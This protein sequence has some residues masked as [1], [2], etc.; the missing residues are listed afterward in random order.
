[1]MKNTISQKL[2]TVNCFELN[3]LELF[4]LPTQCTVL[5]KMNKSILV[6]DNFQLHYHFK[7]VK[8]F[9]MLNFQR[10]MKVFKNS[11]KKH[12]ITFNLDVYSLGNQ[13]FCHCLNAN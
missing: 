7:K 3:L 10:Q 11:N 6:I 8:Q 9:Y 2:H 12:V 4:N 1:M 13:V 5:P